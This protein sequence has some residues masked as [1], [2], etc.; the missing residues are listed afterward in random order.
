MGFFGKLFGKKEKELTKAELKSKLEEMKKLR[1]EIN[2]RQEKYDALKKE[3]TPTMKARMKDGVVNKQVRTKYPEMDEDI[4]FDED[5]FL[6]LVMLVDAFTEVYYELE[7]GDMYY[8]EPVMIN[9]YESVL[10]DNDMISS[11]ISQA[12]EESS[13]TPDP[14]PTR[15]SSYDNDTSYSSGS[16]SY[17][18][19]SSDCGGCD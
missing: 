16:S 12:T 17:D 4:F 14:E 2:E 15:S 5:D 8:E 10:S 13:Y 9:E 11:S 19:G 7:Q 18:S 6:M 1:E 3:V